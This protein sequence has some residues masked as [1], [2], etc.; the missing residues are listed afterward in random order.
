MNTRGLIR[1]LPIK[2]LRDDAE[3][4]NH[5]V[6]QFEFVALNKFLSVFRHEEILLSKKNNK[7]KVRQSAA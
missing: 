1:D 7:V 3:K 6:F 2:N 4:Y 5:Q